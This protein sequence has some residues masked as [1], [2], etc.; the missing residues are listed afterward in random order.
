MNVTMVERARADCMWRALDT[1][2]V[3]ETEKNALDADPETALERQ[4]EQIERNFG[5]EWKW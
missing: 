4:L 5:P 2:L 3:R 1:I